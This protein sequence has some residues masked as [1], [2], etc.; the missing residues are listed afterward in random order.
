VKRKY[1]LAVLLVLA[2]A[3]VVAGL[4]FERSLK[5]RTD[6]YDALADPG[7]VKTLSNSQFMDFLSSGDTNVISETFGAL[8]IR[9]DPFAVEKAKTFLTSKEAYVW[10]NAAMYLGACKDPASTPYLIKAFRHTAW[11]SDQR[12]LKYL[13]EITGKD[14]G[15]NFVQWKN[16]WEEASHNTNFDW[17]S[18]LGLAPRVKK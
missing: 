6:M 5:R 11:R 8:E 18:S 14:Y 10:L 16:W 4:L 13:R 1:I 9:A 2:A 3:I 12:R 17:D 7:V 15:T